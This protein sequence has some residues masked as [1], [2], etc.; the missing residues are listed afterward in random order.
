MAGLLSPFELRLIMTVFL[1]ICW[2]VFVLY[3]RVSRRPILSGRTDSLSG[4]STG[5]GIS[6]GYLMSDTGRVTVIRR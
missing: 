1:A 6:Y 2:T 4:E 3:P 5:H